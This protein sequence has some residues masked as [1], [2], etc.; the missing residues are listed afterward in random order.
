ML[1]AALATWQRE[2]LADRDLQKLMDDIEL[3]LVGIL[4]DMERAGVRLDV[5]RLAEIT[6]RVRAEIRTLETEVWDL[7]GTEFVLGSPQQLG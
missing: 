4:R 6:E 2:Q 3:P 1:T 7:A 5:E